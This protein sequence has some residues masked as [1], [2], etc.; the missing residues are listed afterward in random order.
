[1]GFHPLTKQEG[2]KQGERQTRKVNKTVQ[3]VGLA[4]MNEDG[5]P[6]R[7][8]VWNEKQLW[9]VNFLTSFVSWEMPMASRST[10]AQTTTCLPHIGYREDGGKTHKSIYAYCTLGVPQVHLCL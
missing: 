5:A 2:P 4:C 1:M 7:P 10:P 6:F 8:S 3:S 9:F